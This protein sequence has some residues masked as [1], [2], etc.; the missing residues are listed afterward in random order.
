MMAPLYTTI[1]R[2]FGITSSPQYLL[3]LLLLLLG[4]PSDA[5]R[6]WRNSRVDCRVEAVL[7]AV[8]LVAVGRA[9]VDAVDAVEDGGR[10]EVAAK[11]SVTSVP[12]QPSEG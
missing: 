12:P 3:L 8:Q 2:G 7:R 11:V 1:S 10:G 6:K 9:C 5:W 4:L